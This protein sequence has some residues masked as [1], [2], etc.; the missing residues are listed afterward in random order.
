M[1]GEIKRMIIDSRR[2]IIVIK[3]DI[4]KIRISMRYKSCQEG[5]LIC[6]LIKEGVPFKIEYNGDKLKVEVDNK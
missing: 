2:D 3:E 1:R 6:R 4:K 5:N